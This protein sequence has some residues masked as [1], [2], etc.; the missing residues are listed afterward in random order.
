MRAPRNAVSPKVP[1]QEFQVASIEDKLRGHNTSVQQCSYRPLAP[2]EPTQN[3]YFQPILQPFDFRA[4]SWQSYSE[5]T[6]NTPLFGVFVKS[7][8]YNVTTVRLSET[9][10]TSETDVLCVVFPNFCGRALGITRGM[11]I[12][13]KSTSGWQFSIKPPCAV[14]ENSPVFELC[15]L[16]NLDGIR[17]LFQRGDASPFDQDPLG[18]TPLWVCVSEPALSVSFIASLIKSLGS[19]AFFAGGCGEL[20]SERRS[21]HQ[22]R[23]LEI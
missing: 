10:K 22:C 13:A 19:C 7:F 14:P 6:L 4:R 12:S 8:T 17:T 18:K 3:P 11:L 20:S 23:R 21:R 5:L 2:S 1:K 9:R 16:G 15:R